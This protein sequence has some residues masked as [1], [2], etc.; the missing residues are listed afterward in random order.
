VFEKIRRALGG[1]SQPTSPVT[2]TRYHWRCACGAQSR[3][4]FLIL[5]DVEHAIDRHVW[6]K[7]KGHPVPEIYTTEEVRPY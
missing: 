6:S 5:S 2:R 3:G 4:G 7:G 1:V